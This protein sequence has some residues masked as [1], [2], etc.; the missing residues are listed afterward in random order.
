VLKAVDEVPVARME[1]SLQEYPGYTGND[2]IP[3]GGIAS[4]EVYSDGAFKL[5]LSVTGLEL[6][7]T[8][9]GVHI[10]TGTTCDD[11]AL[12]GDHYWNPAIYGE[13]DPWIA[14]NGAY[15]DAGVLAQVEKYFYFDS[16]YGFEEIKNHSVVLR[17]Q[18]GSGIL[19]GTLTPTTSEGALFG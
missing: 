1:A 3:S 15:Y 8:K 14:A 6:G 17:C 9:C 5:R 4:V 7:C 16:G 10:H 19:C 2:R 18:D 12:V 11:A 13:A